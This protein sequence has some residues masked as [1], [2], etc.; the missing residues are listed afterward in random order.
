MFKIFFY[1]CKTCRTH[2]VAYQGRAVRF[3]AG[4]ALTFS[5][6]DLQIYEPNCYIVPAVNSRGRHCSMYGELVQS[7]NVYS[8]NRRCCTVKSVRLTC[9]TE[10]INKASST[11][12][13]VVDY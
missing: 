8:R 6:S 4:E 2:L 3:V 13:Q 9:F 12:V 10:W 7:H 1:Q 11:K 5:E